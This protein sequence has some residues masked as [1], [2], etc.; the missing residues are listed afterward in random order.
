MYWDLRYDEISPLNKY[1]RKDPRL[2]NK[3]PEINLRLPDIPAEDWV[4]RGATYAKLFRRG[5]GK[6]CLRKSD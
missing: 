1:L 4:G 6:D 2:Y 5:S 3:S